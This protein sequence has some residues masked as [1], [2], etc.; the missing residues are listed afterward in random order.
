MEV[1]GLDTSIIERV[2]RVLRNNIERLDT[3]DLC[4]TKFY[5]PCNDNLENILRYFIV[6]VAMDHRLSRPGKPYE[7]MLEDGF[8]HGADLL[9]RLGM[10]KYS[11]DPGFFD[12]VRLAQVRIEE[13]ESWLSIGGARPP[14]IEARTILLRDLGLKIS[15]LY[16]GRV[17]R[18]IEASRGRLYGSLMEPGF[19]DLLRVFRAYEDPVE[20]K[21][22]LLAKFLAKRRIFTPLDKPGIPVDNHLSRIAYR[23]GIVM[24]SGN[25]WV[26]IREQRE[27]SREEDI[28]LRMVIRRGYEAISSEAGIDPA[29]LDDY[30]WLMGRRICLRDNPPRCDKCLFKGF[31][32]ARRNNSFMVPEHYYYNTWY[33]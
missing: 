1:I 28:L 12:P 15:K 32:R 4:D 25:L 24:V 26:K 20:K 9:Y 7:A 8:Y 29:T 17:T 5:P 6:M 3:L 2:S 18:I 21:S 11:E 31:C 13:V 16:E 22:L 27:V 30:F 10:K 23:L 14:D 33:Y 19:I